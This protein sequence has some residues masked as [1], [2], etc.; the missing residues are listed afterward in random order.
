MADPP[1]SCNL[2]VK[3]LLLSGSGAADLVSRPTPPT[4][5]PN[6][7]AQRASWGPSASISEIGR[8]SHTQGRAL[9]SS[10]NN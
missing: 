9:S 4:H 7:G 5:R 10:N 6:I 1:P 8:L 3:D 2:T